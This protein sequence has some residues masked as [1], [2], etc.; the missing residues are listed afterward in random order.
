M[1]TVK[2]L[3]IIIALFSTSL[4]FAQEKGKEDCSSTKAMKTYL[5]ERD[6]PGAGDLTEKQLQ[7]A[8]EKSCQ[9]LDEL[10]TRIVWLNSYVVDDK[11]YCVYKSESK[12]LIKEHAEKGGFPCTNIMEVKTKIGPYTAQAKID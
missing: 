1:K 7:E 9:V 8:S 2:T 6:M 3:A 12:E 11:L 5:I 10:G 4:V